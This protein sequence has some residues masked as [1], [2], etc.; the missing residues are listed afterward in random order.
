MV[1]D[2]EPN[3]LKSI[4]RTLRGQGLR[5]LTADSGPK[6]LALIKDTE[7]NV[8]VSDN[9]MPAMDGITFLE[10]VRAYDSKITRIMLTGHA[11]VDCAQQAINRSKIFEYLTKP[12]NNEDLKTTIRRSIDHNFLLCENHR[13]QKLTESQNKELLHLNK[14][15]QSRVRQR[16][17]Q[18]DNAVRE[19]L[20]ML[21]LAA[22]AKDEDTG[23]HI[24][25]IQDLTRATC[26]KMGMEEVTAEKI[27]FASIMHD[28]GKI[29]VPDNI[30][31]KKGKLTETEMDVM[32]QHTIAG[33]KILGKSPFYEIARQIARS[34]HERVDGKGYPDGLSGNNIALPARI[35]CVIDVF[36]ALIHERPYK[37]AW[38]KRKALTWMREQVDRQFDRAV[39]AAFVD[40]LRDGDGHSSGE[41][42]IGFI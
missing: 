10:R 39:F 22:E 35:V 25:R 37:A 40:V 3:I 26:K 31:Q 33:E 34:H 41:N 1:V 30:L 6:G 23:N 19:G 9:H 24:K 8:V 18:L 27:A 38:S 13:L 2:D 21:A 32:K 42:D 14:T 12:W 7:V 4:E 20:L 11:S 36:D 16:T 17:S 29:H 15:L 28:V 5:I